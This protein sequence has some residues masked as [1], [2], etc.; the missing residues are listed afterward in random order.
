MKNLLKK[1]FGISRL[2]AQIMALKEL[3][4]CQETQLKKY[5]NYNHYV[6]LPIPSGKGITQYLSDLSKQQMFLFYLMTLENEIRVIFR[7]SKEGDNS[8][9]ALR[10]IDRIREDLKMAAFAESKKNAKV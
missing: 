6:T 8:K 3:V 5:H 4:E 2:E 7:N 9:G 10:I 1:L